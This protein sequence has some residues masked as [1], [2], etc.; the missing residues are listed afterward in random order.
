MSP[1]PMPA[2]EPLASS[3]ALPSEVR[4]SGSVAP[5]ARGAEYESR[6]PNLK[7]LGG[8]APEIRT[9]LEGRVTRHVVS[10]LMERLDC[11]CKRGIRPMRQARYPE[12]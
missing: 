5:H 2:C 1:N 11:A 7:E 9:D 4:P 12:T 6:I 10:L 8:Q 3:S